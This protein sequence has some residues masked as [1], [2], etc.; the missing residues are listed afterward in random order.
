[1]Y[2]DRT[3][4]LKLQ[5]IVT[6]IQM[7]VVFKIHVTLLFVKRE[8]MHFLTLSPP[9]T[10]LVPYANSLDLDETASNSPSHPDPN[11]LTLTQYVH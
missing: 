7:A 3:H 5:Y 1:M 10:I 8:V 9:S 6:Y 2:G 4:G 11:Y